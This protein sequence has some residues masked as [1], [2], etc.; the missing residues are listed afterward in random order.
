MK[1]L[2]SFAACL[3]CLASCNQFKQELSVMSFNIRLSPTED[4]DGENCWNNRR[5]AAMDMIRDVKP[6]L[7]GIQEGLYHQVNFIEESLPEYGR[8]GVGRDDGAAS[9][10]ANAI[11]WLKERFDLV[12]CNTFWLSETPDTVS[13]G[14]DGA[15]NRVVT[16]GHFKDKK[17][18]NRDVFYFNTHF[19]HMGK[20]AREEAGKLIVSRMKEVIPEGAPVFLTGDFNANYDNY[21]LNP[22]REYMEMS[23]ETAAVSD[24]INTYHGWGEI[25]NNAGGVIIDH[26][27]YKNAAPLTYRTVTEQYGVKF[28]SD[29]Y[30]V[31]A[32]FEY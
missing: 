9:G 1:R 20:I 18:G 32:V 19:D 5:E 28:V 17:V 7:F 30:P 29:H 26:I 31:V 25:E 23:R 11:F 2:L 10:E 22:I 6:D 15:C 21:I 13:R 16:W 12:E 4:F 24:T 8:Y 27:F 3:L 14:W